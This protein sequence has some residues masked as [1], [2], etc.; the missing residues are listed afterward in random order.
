[1]ERKASP[2]QQLEGREAFPCA[3]AHS[4]QGLPRTRVF[5]VFV[6]WP[7][8][9][10]QSPGHSSGSTPGQWVLPVPSPHYSCPLSCLLF[11]LPIHPP[12]SKLTLRGKGA[13]PA[14][15]AKPCVWPPGRASPCP[16]RALCLAPVLAISRSCPVSALP[17]G[18]RVG[19]GLCSQRA[20]CSSPHPCLLCTQESTWAAGAGGVG[21]EANL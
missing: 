14:A 21:G 9:H 17:P 16:R 1:M 15:A 4:C 7:W 5:I 10:S 11:D 13:S 6:S 8:S 20:A 18:L 12:H 3:P 19:L 2:T